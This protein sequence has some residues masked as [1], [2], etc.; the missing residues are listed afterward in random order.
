MLR[1]AD[2][3]LVFLQFRSLVASLTQFMEK[4][5]LMAKANGIRESHHFGF[6]KC[7]FAIHALVERQADMPRADTYTT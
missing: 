4:R 7:A 1:R 2:N 6:T 3:H 5:A